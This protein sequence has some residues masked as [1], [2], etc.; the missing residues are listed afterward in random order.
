MWARG[1]RQL[2]EVEQFVFGRGTMSG[3]KTGGLKMED[4]GVQTANLDSSLQEFGRVN[5]VITGRF[6]DM[7]SGHLFIY[8][9]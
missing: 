6:G 7:R 5:R 9:G 3:M 8:H 2:H 4:V 1:L